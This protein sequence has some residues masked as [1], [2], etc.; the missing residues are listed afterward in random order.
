M[1]KTDVYGT[2]FL[3]SVLMSGVAMA[4]EEPGFSV[5]A[6]VDGIEYRQY[7][8][9]LVAETAVAGEGDR[10]KA[11]NV[12]FRRLFGYIS[13]D[14]TVQTEIA[15]TAPVKQQVSNTKIAMT[16]PVRQTPDARGWTVAF[17]VPGEFDEANVPQPTNPD[18]Y[19]RTV[20]GQLMAVLRYSGRWTDDNVNSHKSKLNSKLSAAGLTPDGEVITAFYN[21]PFSLPFMRRNEV[22]VAVSQIPDAPQR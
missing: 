19:I 15:M 21:A 9:Y 1:R 4:Y 17:M 20:P 10:N 8:P 3:F 12:G 16:T 7:Q 13:G 14:N 22:M 5:V 18:V 2:V 11:A 6:D